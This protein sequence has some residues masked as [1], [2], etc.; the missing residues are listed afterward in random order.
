MGFESLLGNEALKA[1]LLAAAR[2]DRFAHSILICG[3]DGAGKHTLA[4]LLAAALQCTG[5]ERPCL[6]CEACRKVLSGVHPDVI[7]VR[8]PAHKTI[9]VDVIRAMRADVFV[10]PNEGRRKIYCIEQDMAESPQNALLKIL[11]EPPDYAVFLILS[12][13]AEKLLPT[14]RSRCAELHLAPVPR[15]EALP[16]LQKRF[17]EKSAAEA[18]QAFFRAGGFLGQAEAMLS[19]EDCAPQVGQFA[20]CYAAR[21]ALALLEMLLPLEKQKR[22]QLIPI[23]TQLRE[24]LAGLLL[25]RSGYG[26]PDETQRRILQSRTG[27]ELLAAADSL[28]TAID[29]LNANVGTGAVIGWL[30]IQLR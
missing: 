9:A 22:E 2:Q 6:R 3:P 26:T 15:A 10:R 20:A 16:F 14:I 24:Y 7:P 25:V 27:A 8:D 19:G 1:R 12:D 29:D 4:R 30:S 5:A 23:L 28:Q 18:E 21:D 11:E 13:R 17:P